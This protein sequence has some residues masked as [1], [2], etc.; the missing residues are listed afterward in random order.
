MFAVSALVAAPPFFFGRALLCHADERRHRFL[1]GQ[2][3]T[4][5]RAQ[6]DLGVGGKKPQDLRLGGKGKI[7]V[8]AGKAFGQGECFAR[9]QILADL[10]RIT[11]Y[12]A[13]R[14][15]V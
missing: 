4:F 5:V 6:A 12:G 7:P 13:G 10:V 1:R 3:K 15:A 11:F 2:E 9:L 8:S 14:G